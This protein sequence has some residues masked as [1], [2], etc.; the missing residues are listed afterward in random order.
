MIQPDRQ[1]DLTEKLLLGLVVITGT[2]LRF[3]DAGSM[4]LTH[5]ELSAFYRLDAPNL[6]A[7][8]DA[9]VREDGHPAGAQVF[10]WLWTRLFGTSDLLCK[11]PFLLMGVASIILSYRLARRWFN[12]TTGLLAAAFM[13][14]L[15]LPV[16]YSQMARPYAS[17]LF[18]SLWMVLSWTRLLFGEGSRRWPAATGFALSAVLCAYNHYFSMLFAVMVGITGLFFLRK[19]TWKWYLGSMATAVLLFLPHLKLFF[20]HLGNRGLTW[21]GPPPDTFLLDYVRY[22]FHF[23]P[24]VFAVVLILVITG[25][26]MNSPGSL[27]PG[28]F[29]IISLVWFIIPP[30]VGFFYSRQVA[31]VV[32]YSVLIFSFPFLLLFLFSGI[33]PA[34]KVQAGQS[35]VLTAT[36]MLVVLAVNVATLVWS[37]DHYQLFYRQP[38]SEYGRLTA[39]FLEEHDQEEVT[40][41]FHQN[42]RYINHY[43]EKDCPGIGFISTFQ[44]GLSPVE[45]RRLLLAGETEY[46]VCGGLPHGLL[47]VAR[48][49]FPRVVRRVDG[50]TYEY[51]ILSRNLRLPAIPGSG[52][53]TFASILNPKSKSSGHWRSFKGFL[54][55][56]P[57]MDPYFHFPPDR[58]WGL[59]FEAP[60]EQMTA[61]RHDFVEARLRF[62]CIAGD[63]GLL[64]CEINRGEEQLLW[65]SAS[66]KDYHDPGKAGEW[67]MAH[68]STRLTDLFRN[69]RSTRGCTVKIYYWNAAG[70]ELLVNQFSVRVR[71]GNPA[72][73]G[74]YQPLR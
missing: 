2:I 16:M 46:L 68:F 4:P 27:K 24:A 29:Q 74:L 18:L 70:A 45:F 34:K 50:F 26:I 23:S 54:P 32:Q 30:L 72:V 53:V 19:D 62:K 71:R 35:G 44:K 7:L 69:A 49:V 9:G 8:I 38:F 15:Q 36:A 65:Y 20:Y 10:L 1:R 51:Y 58:E 60:L 56:S 21:L 59:G 37:R 48:E 47:S 61:S 64:V 6:G 67:Q 22:I 11:L 12:G 39:E 28:R 17:G 55:A 31:P 43:F 40:V 73:Y 33:N 13:A 57:D 63:P 42:P 52:D 25:F 66:L 5:D 3:W 14:T 41:V